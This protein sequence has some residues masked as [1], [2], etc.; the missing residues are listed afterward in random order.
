M[1]GLFNV[2]QNVSL[3]RKFSHTAKKSALLFL[4]VQNVM[5]IEQITSFMSKFQI[6]GWFTKTF[7]LMK[8]MMNIVINIMIIIII[9]TSSSAS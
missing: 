2:L 3:V 9:I 1:A 4:F 7:T 8:I 6:L 5:F